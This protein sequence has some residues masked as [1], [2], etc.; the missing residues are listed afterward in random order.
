[1][2]L[3]ILYWKLIFWFPRNICGVEVKGLP[4]PDQSPNGQILISPTPP[5]FNTIAY[6]YCFNMVSFFLSECVSRGP[7]FTGICTYEYKLII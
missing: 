3:Y 1:M 7:T 4:N 2:V 6:T 5:P